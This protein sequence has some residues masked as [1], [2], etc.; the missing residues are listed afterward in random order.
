MSSTPSKAGQTLH[1]VEETGGRQVTASEI[2]TL[3]DGTEET[4][5]DALAAIDTSYADASDPE[6][7][8]F[9]MPLV[10]VLDESSVVR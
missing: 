3:F 1:Q 5:T 7:G 10:G 8:E 4:P 2:M 6:T 9:L